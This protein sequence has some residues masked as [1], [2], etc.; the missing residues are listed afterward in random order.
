MLTATFLSEREFY[1]IRQ[2]TVQV[3]NNV[4]GKFQTIEINLPMENDF[5]TLARMK[6]ILYYGIFQRY[7][8]I[9][10]ETERFMQ[11]YEANVK[12]RLRAQS[13]ICRY[14]Q[15]EYVG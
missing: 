4:M 13:R 8:E 9:W 11:E 7:I 2:R 1:K 5:R 6:R 3:A 12:N 14:N 15:G 10:T